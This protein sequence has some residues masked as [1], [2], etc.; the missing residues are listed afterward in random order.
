MRCS[1]T[2]SALAIAAARS[3][4]RTQHGHTQQRAR[5]ARRRGCVLCCAA[6]PSLVALAAP[7]P[8]P[9]LHAAPQPIWRRTSKKFCISAAA[10][11]SAMGAMQRRRERAALLLPTRR[12]H[13][14]RRLSARSSDALGSAREQ[15]GAATVPRGARGRHSRKRDPLP[16]DTAAAPRAVAG[17]ACHFTALWRAMRPLCASTRWR[18]TPA[19]TAGACQSV[20]TACRLSLSSSTRTPLSE[21]SR[22]SGWLTRR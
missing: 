19:T 10:R 1:L 15:C 14:R 17:R 9:Y 16:K 4:Q 12:A 20:Q 7:D 3:S 6:E 13:G 5:A 18:L 22:S 11:A 21:A 2:R 8:R